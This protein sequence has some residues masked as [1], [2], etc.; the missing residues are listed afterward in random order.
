MKSWPTPTAEPSAP[1]KATELLLHTQ[2]ALR[3]NGHLRTAIRPSPASRQPPGPS[4]NRA[5]NLHDSRIPHRIEKRPYTRVQRSTTS[6]PVST[7]SRPARVPVGVP[8]PE[9]ARLLGPSIGRSWRSCSDWRRVTTP[10][11]GAATARFARLIS[12][13]SSRHGRLTIRG[14]ACDRETRKNFARDLRNLTLASAKLNR[15]EKA[16]K[17]AAEWLP[18]RNRCWF[19]ARVVEVRQAYGFT[20][21]RNEALALEAV[22]AAC[23]S[24]EM[25]PIALSTNVATDQGSRA[26]PSNGTGALALYDDNRNSPHYL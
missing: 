13:T 23:E 8:L 9:R 24:S 26:S 18:E 4:P 5:K 19:A 7:T 15:Y 6:M 22:L 10:T 3:N 14:C 12:S 11:P 17:D 2:I 25:T 1:T 20:V 21:D 16:G